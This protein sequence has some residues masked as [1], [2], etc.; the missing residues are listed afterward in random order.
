MRNTGVF[1]FITVLHFT[2]IKVETKVN[3]NI[4]NQVST[5]IKNVKSEELSTKRKSGENIST[6]GAE[7]MVT[8]D[9][10]IL[11]DSETEELK[12]DIEYQGKFKEIDLEYKYKHIL[13][14]HP[15][16]TKS[17]RGQQNPVILALLEKGHTVTGIFSEKGDIIHERYN[18]LIVSTR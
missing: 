2:I 10:I 3:L 4:N 15:W 13:M 17:H 7:K 5:K 8:K 18:E 16:G 1:I 9:N 12:A 14:Y 11:K 6:H